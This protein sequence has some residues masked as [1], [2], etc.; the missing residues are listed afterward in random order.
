MSRDRWECIKS[1]LYLRDN[2]DP[3]NDDRLFKIVDHLRKIFSSISMDQN[4]CV[5]KQMVSFKGRYSMKQFIRGK[6]KKWGFK[7]FV[8]D[9]VNGYIY[10]LIPYTGKIIPS[11]EPNTPDLGASS[12]VVVHL[13]LNIVYTSITDLLQYH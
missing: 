2:N 7:I 4:L 11:N 8:L 9:D 1:C 10:D 13:I 5:D 3:T 6:K 12:N